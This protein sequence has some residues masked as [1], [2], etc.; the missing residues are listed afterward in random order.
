VEVHK[1][2]VLQED[3]GAVEAIKVILVFQMEELL[4]KFQ[5]C[6]HHYNHLVMEMQ[7]ELVTLVAEAEALEVLELVLEM[8]VLEEAGLAITH[9]MLVVVAE[10]EYIMDLVE[11]AEQAAEATEEVGQIQAEQTQH[12]T[13]AEVVVEQ[14]LP[15]HKALVA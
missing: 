3:L 5:V 15:Q 7:V 11:L 4:L 9:F 12:L 13:Q 2:L 10:V 1:E 6:L 8:V 14:V